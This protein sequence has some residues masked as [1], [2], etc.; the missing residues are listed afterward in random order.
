MVRRT[1][2]QLNCCL[3]AVI[4]DC[5]HQ[6]CRGLYFL[7]W[8]SRIFHLMLGSLRSAVLAR[9]T[10]WGRGKCRRF[11][12]RTHTKRRGNGP[13]SSA[14]GKDLVHERFRQREEKK[15]LTK[16]NLVSPT[17]GKGDM[18]TIGQL[19]IDWT[20][21]TIKP[22]DICEVTVTYCLR[23]FHK[24]IGHQARKCHRAI[25]GFT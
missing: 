21:P 19:K 3:Y 25:L 6:I 22:V 12:E 10:H 16:G 14:R 9:K 2:E 11:S 23:R 20:V 18:K 13:F 8:R 7:F 1:L 4:A 17:L 5:F 24:S 15:I